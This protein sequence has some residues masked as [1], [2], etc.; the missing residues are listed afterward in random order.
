MWRGVFVTL[1]LLIGAQA[2]QAEPLSVKEFNEKLQGWK[3]EKRDPSNL[4]LEV[5]GRVKIYSKD[6]LTM[7]NCK[8][9]FL[10]NSEFPERTRKSLNVVVIGKVSRDPKTS[11]HTFRVASIRIVPGELEQF[12]EKRR[13]IKGGAD[14]WYALGR[15]AAERGEFYADDKLLSDAEFAYRRGLDIDRKVKSKDDPA[16]LLELA[17]KAKQY[18]MLTLAH[19]LTHEAYYLLCEQS[20]NQSPAEIRALAERLAAALPGA[21]DKSLFIPSEL[22]SDYKLRPIPTYTAADSMT[23]RKLHRWLYAEL[24]LRLITADLKPDGSNGFEIA[25]QIDL[26]VPREGALADEYR[27]RALKARAAEVEKLTRTQVLDLFEQYRLL[28]QQRKADDVLESWLALRKQGLEPDDTEGLLVLSDDYRR[29]LKRNDLA[30]RL[31]IEGWARNPKA[32]DLQERLE[33]EG[34]KLFDGRWISE[35]DFANR[36]EGKLEKAIRAGLVEPGMTAGQVR[37]SRGQPDSQA[38]SATAGQVTEF[39]TYRMA[40]SSQIIVR[41]VKRAGQAEMSVAD[42]AEG[43]GR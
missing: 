41:F 24:Q 30:D 13:H 42:V 10:S 6:R 14:E 38:R 39:W 2:V 36:P 7:E 21:D 33:K 12:I 23:R 11:E 20:R 15:W 22:I 1:L 8:V 9:R 17:D 25:K 3:A 19:E 29:L 4:T 28:N 40:D 18:R 35:Q 43:K 5:E 26:V 34:Y 16:G 32:I 27:A 31:L 37:R